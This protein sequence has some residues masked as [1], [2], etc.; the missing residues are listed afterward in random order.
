MPVQY[1]GRQNRL[2]Q[3]ATNKQATDQRTK[4]QQKKEN[5]LQKILK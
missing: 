1:F 3:E 4:S 5:T 2:K